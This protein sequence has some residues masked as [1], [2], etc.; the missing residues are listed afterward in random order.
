MHAEKRK[1]IDIYMLMKRV[2]DTQLYLSAYATLHGWIHALAKREDFLERELYRYQKAGKFYDE[3]EKRMTAAGK[4]VTALED[5]KKPLNPR[6]IELVEKIS[7]G[8]KKKADKY[9]KR[10]C[11]GTLTAPQLQQVWKTAQKDGVK[12]RRSRYDAPKATSVD[13][14]DDN[15]APQATASD[16]IAALQGD[17]E[18]LPDKAEGKLPTLKNTYRVLTEFAVHTGSA[19]RA[20]R[21]DAAVIETISTKEIDVVRIHAIE[22]KV[23]ISDLQHDDKM[24]EYAMFSDYMWICVPDREDIVKAAEDYINDVSDQRKAWGILAASDGAVRAGR[25]AAYNPGVMRDKALEHAVYLL[26]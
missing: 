8:D 12:A 25:K 24:Y 3:Y 4:P 20:R 18:W 13:I 17:H 7:A 11:E 9:M 22:N 21:M 2:Q 6:S 15:A 26:V 19:D 23:S 5:L 16:L 10:V 1:W 14:D